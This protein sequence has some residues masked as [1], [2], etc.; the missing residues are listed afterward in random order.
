M[1]FVS[2]VIFQS[3]VFAGGSRSRFMNVC[4]RSGVR[5]REGALENPLMATE[6]QRFAESDPFRGDP[7]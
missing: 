4:S 6:W 2:V 7:G 5:Q 1:R 3:S